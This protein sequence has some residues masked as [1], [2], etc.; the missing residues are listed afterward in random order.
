MTKKDAVNAKHTHPHQ[1]EHGLSN[2][3]STNYTWLCSARRVLD[4][5]NYT[6]HNKYPRATTVFHK[7]DRVDG[8][9]DGFD[10]AGLFF[11]GYIS[12]VHADST[13]D[14]DYDDGDKE[15]RVQAGFIRVFEEAGGKA[16]KVGALNIKSYPPK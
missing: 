9:Y 14:I 6:L 3:C 5:D 8:L 12:K 13:Y 2:G 11:P 1:E 4:P 15:T 7:G 16:Y 10:G